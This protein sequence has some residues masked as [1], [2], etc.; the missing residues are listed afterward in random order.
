[1]E[2]WLAAVGASAPAVFLRGSFWAYPLVNAGHI[3]GIALLVGPIVVLDAR[4]L[5][6]HRAMPLGDAAR[7]LLPFTVGG[8][9]LAIATGAALF[10]VKPL[11]YAAIPV[12]QAKLVLIGLALVNAA[13]L[14]TRA[15]WRSSLA[16][17]TPPDLGMKFAA[18]AS[19]LLWLAVLL[20]GRMIAFVW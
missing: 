9:A 7:L 20:A 16:W 6:F 3:L 11:D 2:A 19:I 12:F 8:L 15:A 13:A 18:A 14:R 17:E 1:M 4:I 5:G 10:I